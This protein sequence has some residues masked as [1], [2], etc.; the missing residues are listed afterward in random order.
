MQHS[1]KVKVVITTTLGHEEFLW[2]SHYMFAKEMWDILQI[3]H[4]G[5]TEV[6]RERLG[7]LTNECELFRIKHEESINQMQIR[8]THIGSHIRIMGKNS[9][10]ELVIK[11]LRCLNHSWQHNVTAI[12]ESKNLATMD[13]HTHTR[14]LFGKLQEHEIELKRLA[15]DEEDNKKKRKSITSKIWN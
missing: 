5:N 7:T 10:E 14:T 3:T 1:F 11:I 12:Y 13:T 9:N 2:V 8:F 4:E 6:N 15:D